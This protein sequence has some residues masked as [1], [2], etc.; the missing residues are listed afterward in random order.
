MKELCNQLYKDLV[1]RLGELHLKEQAV[2]AEVEALKA[3]IR[4]LDGI[5]PRLEDKVA[6]KIKSAEDAVRM[7]VAKAKEAVEA[8]LQEE[9]E[10]LKAK[11]EKKS[12]EA[13]GIVEND[14]NKIKDIAKAAEILEWDKK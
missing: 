9:K 11:I 13:L 2:L 4:L 3:Q 8:K 7:E 14:I 10:A 12:T 6:Q 5:L 1:A